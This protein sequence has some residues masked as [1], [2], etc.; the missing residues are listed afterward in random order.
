MSPANRGRV[1]RRGAGRAAGPGGGGRRRGDASRR[2]TSARRRAPRRRCWPRC[3]PSALR[4]ALRGGDHGQ[5]ARRR[6][7]VAA[8]RRACSDVL[9]P[10]LEAT[11]DF[12]Q[13]AGRRHKDVWEHTKQVVRQSVPK[14]DVRWAALL[15]DIGK[16]PT[17]GSAARRPGHLPPPRRGGR[18]HVRADRAG[19]WASTSPT[20]T[21][22]G[23]SSCTTCAR[24]RTRRP[25]PTRPCGGSTT[26]WA[27]TWTICSTCRAP[28]SPHAGRAAARRPPA[29]STP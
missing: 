3:R 6:P 24:T 14:P 7:A 15:H 17:R 11:V 26:R 20:A 2:P 28:T 10:E 23:S 9:L 8:R 4:A 27:S 1:P 25:G 22:S 13:E 16:V 5:G 18:A 21:R 12:S 29:T 19:G